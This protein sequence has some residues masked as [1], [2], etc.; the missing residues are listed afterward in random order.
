MGYGPGNGMHISLV[1]WKYYHQMRNRDLN[2][3]F[4]D[5]GKEPS[6]QHK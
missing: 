4:W 5:C 6:Y 3:A 2:Y 1:V